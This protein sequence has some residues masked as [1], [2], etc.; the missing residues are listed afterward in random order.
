MTKEDI[1]RYR[2]GALAG[3]LYD[4]ED[5]LGVH[6]SLHFLAG[7]LGIKDEAEGF[8]E[9]A[10]ASKEGIETATKVYFNKRAKALEGTKI[11]DIGEYFS[12]YINYVDS[13]KSKKLQKAL[14]EYAERTF[15][16]IKKEIEKA[17]YILKGKEKY[18]FNQKEIDESKKVLEKYK[19]LFQIIGTV[20]KAEIDDLLPNVRKT[21]HKKSL[22][23]IAKDL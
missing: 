23:A 11:K 8:I 22:E 10:M 13:E 7:D 6:E 5:L 16:E 15:G 3:A 19:T 17:E 18:E 14:G 12:D 9:G 4:T 2:Y 21:I 20:E 1:K